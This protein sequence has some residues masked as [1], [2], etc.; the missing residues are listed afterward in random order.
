MTAVWL[1]WL[2]LCVF[3]RADDPKVPDNLHF[4]DVCRYDMSDGKLTCRDLGGNVL[5]KGRRVFDFHW[6]EPYDELA[7]VS[8]MR[9]EGFDLGARV[10]VP[11]TKTPVL[12][13]QKNGCPRYGQ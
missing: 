9:R 6:K 4:A 2:G 7:V 11:K 1:V 3:A 13:F 8:M 10:E 12:Y 5:V